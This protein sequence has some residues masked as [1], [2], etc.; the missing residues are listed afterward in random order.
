VSASVGRPATTAGAGPA[1]LPAG[2]ARP[3]PLPGVRAL[4]LA[5]A[6]GSTG[7]A[8]GGTA[9]ALVGARLMGGAAAAG[10]PL[11]LLV[12]GSAGAAMLIARRSARRGR[13]SSLAAGYLA[14]AAGAALVVVATAAGSVAA[15]LAGSLLLGAANAAIFLTRYAAAELGGEAAR[16]RA[17]GAVLAATAVGA[18]VSPNLLGPG[19]ALAGAVGLPRL[20]GLYL[21]AVLVFALA[22]AI[23]ARPPAGAPR[24]ARTPSPGVGRR[25]LLDGLRPRPVREAVALLALTNLVMVAVMA[26]APVHLMDDG[27]ELAGVGVVISVHV[28]G[29]FAPSS[30]TGRLADRIGPRRV[31]AA[32][33]W[34]F[35]TAGVAGALTP[36][37]GVVAATL[38]LALV[39]VG[40]NCGVVGA[41]T[42]LAASVGDGLRMHLEGIGE[43]AMGLAAAAGAPL[44]GVA[45]AVSSLAAV[46]LAAATCAVAVLVVLRPDRPRRRPEELIA[47]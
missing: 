34:L 5:T 42:L 46:W 18:I 16:G 40:W 23:L 30:L 33:M 27:E 31:V 32:G 28:A 25:A 35:V 3:A 36:D 2:D 1:P 17:L 24:G 39:G 11:G 9:G 6:I 45:L 44:A 8:A 4:A 19:G 12:I 7:L 22:A 29:M 43:A 21:V 47:R 26:V 13:P 15:L 37:R 20:S 10:V 38:V 14:G 41:S